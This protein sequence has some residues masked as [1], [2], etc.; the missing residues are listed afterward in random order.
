MIIGERRER[1]VI[2]MGQEP[3]HLVLF[4]VPLVQYAHDHGKV[5]YG[6]SPKLTHDAV[7]ESPIDLL[8]AIAF[9]GLVDFTTELAD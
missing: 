5:I 1:C 2:P 8:R 3:K 7:V 9:A 6:H 4:R